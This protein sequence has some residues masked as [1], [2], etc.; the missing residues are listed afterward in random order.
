MSRRIV[1]LGLQKERS[2]Q[3]AEQDPVQI[4]P[5]LSAK[6]CE[7]TPDLAEKWLKRNHEENRPLAEKAVQSM[8]NDMI[9]GNWRL[10]HQAIAFNGDGKLIDGQHRLTAVVQS[11]TPIQMLVIWNET[12]DLKDP[13]DRNRPRSIGFITGHRSN[14]VAALTILRSFEQGFDNKS[15]ITVSETEEQYAKH[16]AVLE[17][18]I[19]QVPRGYSLL[20]GMLGACAWAYPINSD[21]VIEFATKVVT[22]EML[23]GDD[24]AYAYR[25]WKDRNKNV[26]AWYMALATA[27]CV[28]FQCYKA[29]QRSV[30]TGESGY[31]WITTQRR[32]QKVPNTPGVD[33]VPS[34]SGHPAQDRNH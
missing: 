18:L 31:R 19:E 13:I 22:G 16:G 24:P 14:V 2:I 32:A 21:A 8:V 17:K 9:S 7:V 30:Y 6:V 25:S 15:P 10:T 4:A 5:G 20:S 12:S 33:I 23:M 3:A 34:L 29:P 28:R 27:N 1:P 26:G 11:K